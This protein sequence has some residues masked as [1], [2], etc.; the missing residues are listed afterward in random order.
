MAANLRRSV[1]LDILQSTENTKHSS[2]VSLDDRR[3][4]AFS[5]D[6]CGATDVRLTGDEL[7]F[8]HF[9]AYRLRVGG[10]AGQE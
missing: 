3:I 6:R 2:V 9:S 8:Q 5:T 10:K 1:S 4:V 7:R